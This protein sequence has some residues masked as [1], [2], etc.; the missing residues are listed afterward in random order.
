LAPRLRTALV[1]ITLVSYSLVVGLPAM[2]I[3]WALGMPVLLYRLSV[4][5]S[6][7]ALWIG[8]VRIHVSGRELLDPQQNYLFMPNHCSNVDPPVVVVAL[9]RE[10]L[11]MAKASL[12]RIPVFGHVMAAVGFVPVMR[13]DRKTALLAIEQAGE[14]LVEGHDFVIF[15][16]GTRSRD[17]TILPLKK[18]PFFLAQVGGVP[19]V[20]IRVRGTRNIMKRGGKLIYAGDV[21]VEICPPIQVSDGELAPDAARR[22]LRRRVSDELSGDLTPRGHRVTPEAHE[23]A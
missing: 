11:M 7:A 4:A 5:V 21:E 18:G 1:V 12:F 6:R 19:V 17:D 16:E 2:L 20:P 8:G 13:S 3:A 14:R 15:P 9:R 23:H 10:P 22:D